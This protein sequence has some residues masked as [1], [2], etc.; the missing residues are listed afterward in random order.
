TLPIV[1]MAEAE[2]KLSM[3]DH[4]AMNKTVNPQSAIRNPQL[5]VPQWKRWNDYGIGLLE[6]AQYGQASRAFR[7]ASELSPNDP[8]PLVSDAIAELGTERFGH[9]KDQLQK[10]TA[11]VDAALRID[12]AHWRTKFYKAVVLRAAG[13]LSEAADVLT[14]LSI[15]FPRD[16]EV[17]R[18]LGQ[19]LF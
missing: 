2:R 7:Q 9:E 19:I 10:A 3:S 6:Q 1:R 14:P 16:R 12:Q 8:N 13:R 15:A 11:L 18:Q 17:Q 4:P 5:R